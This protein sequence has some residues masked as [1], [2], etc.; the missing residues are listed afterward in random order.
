[1]KKLLFINK[2]LF[3]SIKKMKCASILADVAIL[4]RNLTWKISCKKKNIFSFN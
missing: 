1:M 2:I 3:K 4:L